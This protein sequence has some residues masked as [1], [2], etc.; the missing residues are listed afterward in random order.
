MKEESNEKVSFTLWTKGISR[1]EPGI[2]VKTTCI[3]SKAVLL[4]EGE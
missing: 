1:K 4:K 3:E 2:D